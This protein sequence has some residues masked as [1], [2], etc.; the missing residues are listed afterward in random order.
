[1]RIAQTCRYS[2]GVVTLAALAG[3]AGA[4]SQPPV[5]PSR[6]IQPLAIRSGLPF[7]VRPDRRQS[8]MARGASS[9]T[10]LYVSDIGAEAVDVFTYPDL[11][12]AGTL[13]GFT[14]PNGLCIDAK[15]DVFVTNA[16]A[17]EILEYAHG[18]TTPIATL[19]DD[20][21]YASGCSVDP[22]TGNLA[23]AN[24]G[25]ANLGQ[26]NVA[27]YKHAKGTPTLYTSVDMY[28]AF[29]CGYDNAGNLFVDGFEAYGH[30]VLV[31]FA[32]GSGGKL[33]T[34]FMKDVQLG[35]P[36]E[37][38]WHRGYLN[39]GDQFANK[40]NHSERYPNVI[41]QLKVSNLIGTL[42]S[43]VQL[44]GGG[45]V[46]DYFIDGKTIVGP[47][48]SNDNVGFWRYPAGGKKTHALTGFYEPVGAVLSPA[49]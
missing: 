2:A 32:K 33:H 45:D 36:G 1:M 19:K 29:Y 3:C 13:T 20:Y 26:G 17:Y 4:V 24:I 42:V 39:L 38:Q 12:P 34:I 41:Y 46:V 6:L 11:K 7:T 10:L 18:G 35:W 22:V 28:F 31:E 14:E 37:V 16:Y 49:Q 30:D 9:Q 40:F 23:V 25:S 43:T 48:A 8:W 44:V 21:Y 15:G 5:G 47:D 27:I